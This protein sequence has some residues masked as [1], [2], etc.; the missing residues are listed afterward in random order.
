MVSKELEGAKDDL[1]TAK[2]SLTAGDY[3]WATKLAV[4]ETDAELSRLAGLEKCRRADLSLADC[5]VLAAAK[6]LSHSS[7]DRQ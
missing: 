1:E 2:K 6:R 3:K 5:Y 4:V 7:H